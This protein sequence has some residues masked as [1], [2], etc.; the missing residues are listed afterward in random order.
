M[1]HIVPRP[2]RLA[3]LR[4]CGVR[5]GRATILSGSI[6]RASELTIGDG[7]FIN[8]RCIVD[9]GRIDIGTNAYI[10]PQVTL[11]G[12]THGIGGSTKRA[13]DDRTEPIVV[14]DGSW[15]G[16]NVVVLAGVTIA[17]GCVIGAGA[18][19]TRSTEPD[20]VYVGV[21]AR[22]IRTLA[23]GSSASVPGS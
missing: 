13:S 18:V 17:P 12:G 10:G 9:G 15:V 5:V 21:P 7:V 22:R 8:H 3:I 16:A 6:F 20:G 1:S 23:S 2:L 14:G 11:A 4:V 19:V